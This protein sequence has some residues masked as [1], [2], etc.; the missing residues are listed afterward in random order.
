M[1]TN[2]IE[3]L[4][5]PSK[6][7]MIRIY[8]GSFRK[9]VLFDVFYVITRAACIDILEIINTQETS[10]KMLASIPIGFFMYSQG[11]DRTPLSEKL[12]KINAYVFYDTNTRKGYLEKVLEVV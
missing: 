8:Q 4:Q 7:E 5:G 6:E 11:E 12:E 9:N 10:V 3:I 2:K 1:D